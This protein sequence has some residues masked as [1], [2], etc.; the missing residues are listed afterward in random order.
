M[1]V[2]NAA[3]VLM[4]AQASAQQAFVKLEGDPKKEAWWV[5]A[6]FQPFTTGA[7]RSPDGAE[8]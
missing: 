4:T 5:I 3:T 2:A 7:D 1:I 8:A 6:Q